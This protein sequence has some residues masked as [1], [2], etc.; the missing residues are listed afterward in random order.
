METPNK[1]HWQEALTLAWHIDDEKKLGDCQFDLSK[2]YYGAG[3][4]PGYFS[5]QPGQYA[6]VF[7]VA[8]PPE[9]DSVILR[10][11]DW[12]S[13]YPTMYTDS[14]FNSVPQKLQRNPIRCRLV[15]KSD[16]SPPAEFPEPWK[17]PSVANLVAGRKVFASTGSVEKP[18]KAEVVYH[19]SM[20][21]S[22]SPTGNTAGGVVQT[23]VIDDVTLTYF[24]PHPKILIQEEED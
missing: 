22:R 17:N 6:N 19:F 2:Q 8:L 7:D 12:T 21:G 3:G 10:S 15:F 4:A 14:K 16:T 18:T 13:Y 20:V 24:L 23:P 11:V 1:Q 5:V 9:V